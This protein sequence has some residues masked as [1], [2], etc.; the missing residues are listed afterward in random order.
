MYV[1]Q[2]DRDKERE[3]E[4]DRWVDRCGEKLRVIWRQI[5]VLSYL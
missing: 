5:H 1:R 2:N 4:R 3:R